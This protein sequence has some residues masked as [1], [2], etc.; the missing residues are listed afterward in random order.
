MERRLKN[1]F[2][3][4]RF[5]NNPRLARLID[6]TEQRYVITAIDDEDLELVSAAGVTDNPSKE[7]VNE[8]LSA[9][10]QQ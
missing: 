6:E 7:A 5:E 2:D 1:L 3:Y 10:R 8:L 9:K 4:Q